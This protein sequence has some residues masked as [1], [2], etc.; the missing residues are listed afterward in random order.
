MAGAA[1]GLFCALTARHYERLLY[2]G[3]A[4]DGDSLA[5]AMR[6]ALAAPLVPI[7]WV[8]DAGRADVVQ[9]VASLSGGVMLAGMVA[10]YGAAVAFPCMVAATLMMLMLACIDA[11][12][13][14]LPDA[15]TQPLLWLGLLVAWNGAW[16]GLDSAI[17]GVIAGY[18]LMAVPRWLWW[19]MRRQDAIGGGDVKMLAALGAWV[20]A[21]GV[22]HVL[23]LACVAGALFTAL[24]QRS[25]RPSGT[26][27]FG[28]FIALAGVADL[29]SPSGLQSTFYV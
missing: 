21:W 9:L 12:T 5:N 1:L 18:A 6:A 27:P 17:A 7:I 20:G 19:F 11:R 4:A 3:F 26:Y 13:R 24:H 28:P 22:A 15:L 8:D 25:W 23:M 29:L 16:L 14:L 10:R 2:A